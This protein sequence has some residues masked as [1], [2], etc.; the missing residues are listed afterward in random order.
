MR[1]QAHEQ[2]FGIFAS[3]RA[4]SDLAAGL[5]TDLKWPPDNIL[6]PTVTSPTFLPSTLVYNRAK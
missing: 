6:L 3:T 2:F 1:A 5:T 4:A